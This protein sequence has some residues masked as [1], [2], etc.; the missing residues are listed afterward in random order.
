MAAAYDHFDYPQFWEDREY[1]HSSEVIALSAFLNKIPRIHRLL[2]IGAGYGRL[3]SEYLYRSDQVYLLD[4]SAKLLKKARK[5]F[6]KAKNIRFIHSS[7]ENVGNKIKYGTFDVVIII[8]VL[9]HAD[10]LGK[11]I[12]NV[13]KYIDADGYLIL[14]YANKSNFKAVVREFFKGN[15]TYSH[16][17]STQDKRTTSDST[18][19]FKNY[20]PHVVEQILKKYDYKIIEKRSVSNI[21]NPFIKKHLPLEFLLSI[22]KLL[23][24]I[25]SPINFGPSI[26]IIAQ[27]K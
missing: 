19:P 9:H 24:M 26:F 8:R 11:F 22:E 3:T 2:D 13:D 15:I 23:Q 6:I 14:E 20:H 16:D 4:S 21:R 27:K 18:F 5:R 17:I 12:R 10:D 1:E 25:L 7:I